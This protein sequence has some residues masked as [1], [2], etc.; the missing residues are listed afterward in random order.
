MSGVESWYHDCLVIFLSLTP[1]TKER[2]VSG[3]FQPDWKI[4]HSSFAGARTQTHSNSHTGQVIC[5]SDREIGEGSVIIRARQMVSHIA[6][7]GKKERWVIGLLPASHLREREASHLS[8]VCFFSGVVPDIKRG[9]GKKCKLG[10]Q[11]ERKSRDRG[12]IAVFSSYC[13]GICCSVGSV[14]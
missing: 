7:D 11:Q 6:P 2:N 12:V 5:Q 10:P 8:F 14:F 3:F 9:W 4:T 1:Y 13:D